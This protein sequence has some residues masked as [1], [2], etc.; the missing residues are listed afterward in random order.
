MESMSTAHGVHGKVWGSVKY[1]LWARSAAPRILQLKTTMV[2]KVQ[3]NVIK[4][5]DLAIFN[6]P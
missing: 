3:W 4:H 1:S 5:N 6:Q 2:S